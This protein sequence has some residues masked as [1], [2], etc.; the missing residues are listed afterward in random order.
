MERYLFYWKRKLRSTRKQKVQN[1]N[2]NKELLKN[3][4]TMIQERETKVTL[5]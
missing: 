3:E 4:S 2:L 5:I 1:V